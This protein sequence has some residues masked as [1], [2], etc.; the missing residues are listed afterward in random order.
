WT[1]A[2]RTR[3]LYVD[4][5]PDSLDLIGFVLGDAGLHCSVANT[6]SEAERLMRKTL[7]DLYIVDHRL[8]DGSGIDFI[9]QIRQQDRNTPVIFVSADAQISV[10]K[11]ALQVGADS[12][13]TKPFDPFA[14]LISAKQRI[15]E[16]RVKSLH[17]RIEERAAILDTLTEQARFVATTLADA[18]AA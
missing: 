14:V 5:H 12:A 18:R 3:V 1:T 16:A 6:R 11:R 7:F 17:A 15:A 10:Q 9:R 8:P 4:D 2:E 13:F